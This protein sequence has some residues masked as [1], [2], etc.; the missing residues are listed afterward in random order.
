LASAIVDVRLGLLLPQGKIPIPTALAAF[1]PRWRPD[2]YQRVLATL[3]AAPE[4]L[5]KS[6][7]LRHAVDLEIARV[8]L[9]RAT[10][11]LERFK[12]LTPVLLRQ[13]LPDQAKGYLREIVHTFLLGFDAACIALCRSCFEQL[14]KAVL[15]RAGAATEP[16]LRRNQPTAHALMANLKRSALI[17]RGHAAGE[18][19]VQRV[20]TVMHKGMYENRILATVSVDSIRDLIEVSVDL[21]GKW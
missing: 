6:Q 2:D 1:F 16:E 13:D 8:G 3:A 14:A 10:D 12:L 18:R 17:A 19:I 7:W 15:L 9:N 20:N 5:D 11:G 21:A 4:I